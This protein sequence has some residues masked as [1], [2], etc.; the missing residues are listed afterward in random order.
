MRFHLGPVPQPESP[1][2]Q[3]GNWTPL[4]EAGPGVM[5]LFALPIGAAMC[6]CVVYA[7]IHATPLIKHPVANLPAMI[8]G[9]FVLFPVHE[10]LHAVVHPKCGISRRSILGAWPSRM[11]FYAHYDGVL[12]RN[13]FIAIL[14]M[15]LLFITFL[16]LAV[17]MAFGHASVTIAFL[18]SLN[19][20][21]AG[22]DIFGIG[23][24]LWQ[25]PRSADVFNRGWRTYWAAR[26]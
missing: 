5:Q 26:I 6:A 16:P 13:R 7:W 15:P 10:L 8:I 12:S 3:P 2:S 18:S 1:E 11:L 14:G 21:A 20:L 22:G 19:A 17:A 25:V 23:L 4:R 24:L 9:M